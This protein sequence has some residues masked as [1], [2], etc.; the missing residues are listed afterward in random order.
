[1]GFIS[2]FRAEVRAF[3]DKEI[4]LLENFA[5]QAV[6]AIENTRLITETRE[7][8]EQQTA[9]AE[10]LQVINASPGN[11]T[12]VFDAML[13]K[14]IR[15][16]E[17][18]FGILRTWD[19]ERLHLVAARGDPQLIE[20]TRRRGPFRP[21]DDDSPLG[22]IVSG[23]QVV[24]TADALAEGAYQT[25]AGF[26]AMVDATGFRSGVTLALRKDAALLGT[27]TVYRIG[28]VRPFTDKQVALLQNFAAQA[29]IAMENARL[30]NEI[31]QRQAELRVTFD[32]MADGVV[33]FDGD[34]RL[35]AWNGNFQ[36]LL[37]LPDAVLSE[38]RSYAE[39]SISSPSAANS[40]TSSPLKRITSGRRLEHTDQGLPLNGTG[41]TAESSRCVAT[42]CRTAALC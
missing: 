26:R 42:R 27:V 6:I 31:R 14:A 30:L 9:T 38:R 37:D 12:P 23:E 1:M 10:V 39:S 16:C 3:S 17:A 7:A 34:L 28:E 21:D 19:E 13:E 22:R 11:L 36:E 29:V 32:N 41:R 4:A 24:H 20:W 35:A 5:D 18:E 40:A 33:M 25:S 2:A 15:L 8:L